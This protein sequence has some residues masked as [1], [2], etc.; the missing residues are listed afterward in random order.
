MV[1]LNVVILV[2]NCWQLRA[3]ARRPGEKPVESVSED[4]IDDRER[5]PV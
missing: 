2:V 3:L 5:A 4:L 1:A